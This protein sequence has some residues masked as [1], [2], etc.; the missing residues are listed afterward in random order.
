VDKVRSVD[1][2]YA[3][4][5]NLGFRQHFDVEVDEIIE[6]IC[7]LEARDDPEHASQRIKQI[8]QAAVTTTHIVP[9]YHVVSRRHLGDG[10]VATLIDWVRKFLIESIYRP[11]LT[12]FLD[13]ENWVRS[14]DEIIRVG[15]NATI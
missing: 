8:R 2:F 12:M 7:M 13:T 10:P 6:K 3:V 1:G 11:L 14:P 5:Y 9:G 15:V 4:S